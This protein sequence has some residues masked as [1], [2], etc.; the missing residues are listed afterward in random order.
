MDQG[1]EYFVH[2][3]E[4]V[5]I[6]LKEASNKVPDGF[7][8]T[9]SSFANTHGGTIYLGIKRRSCKHNFVE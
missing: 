1:K 9:Y 7:Y 8:E 2:L 5:N 3:K 6:E 4:D